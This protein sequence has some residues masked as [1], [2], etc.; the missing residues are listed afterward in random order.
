MHS[1][2]R[3]GDL[4]GQARQ[5]APFFKKIMYAVLGFMV[6]LNLFIFPLHPHFAGEWI[7]GFWAVF[8]VIGAVLL[9]RIC[10]GAAHTFL[11]KPEDYYDRD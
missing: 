6:L 3:L 5:N 1:Q 2:N 9:V 7:P 10:K 8:S 4:L 11:G